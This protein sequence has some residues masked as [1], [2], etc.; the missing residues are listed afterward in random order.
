[1]E[2]GGIMNYVGIDLHKKFMHLHCCDE[3]MNESSLR[4]ENDEKEVNKFF[5][6]LQ[7]NCKAGVEAT[8]NWYWLVDLLQSLNIEV[9]LANPLQTKA[10]AYARVKNDKVDSK[11]LAYLL[12]NDLL[13]TC[14]IPDREQRNNRDMLRIRARLVRMNTVCKNIIRSIMGKFNITPPYTNIWG[15]LGR[16]FLM[17][18]SLGMPYDE[19]VKNLL[20]IIDDLTVQIND[21]DKRIQEQVVLSEA[22]QQ[23]LTVPGVGKIWALT[24]LYE[25][26]PIER[27][28]S[29]KSYIAYAG[30]AP[31]TWET[32]GKYRNGH[33]C[34]QAN[35]Y[36]K[37]AYIEVATVAVK[38]RDLDSV[39]RLYY[40]R[41]VKR[42][43][44]GVAKVALARKIA[45]IV[46]YML[47]GRIDYATCMARRRVAG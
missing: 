27:F 10:I 22:A 42:K 34:K 1:M 23:L 29:A 9:H 43:G 14:W 37:Y 35:M 2:K 45:M 26:G 44:K 21:W 8:G 36:L 7:N 47:R 4:I 31:K 16:E 32:G 38:A 28:Y 18:L 15:S 11:T 17:G 39:L 6:P 3:N 40:H 19:I 46:Y 5:V 13:P 33:L 24:I 41:L 30:L 12:K 25:T 20:V